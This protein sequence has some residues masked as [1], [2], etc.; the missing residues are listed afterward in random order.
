MSSFTGMDDFFV[1][2]VLNPSLNFYNRVILCS[3]YSVLVNEGEILRYRFGDNNVV[4]PCCQN[5][6]FS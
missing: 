2:I 5:D 1:C 6:T 3:D 4:S